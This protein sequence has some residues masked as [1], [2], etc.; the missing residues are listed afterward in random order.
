MPTDKKPPAEEPDLKVTASAPRV[1]P[2]DPV[3]EAK[4]TE[5]EPR[6]L[7]DPVDPVAIRDAQPE[8]KPKTGKDAKAET[9]AAHKEPEVMPKRDLA[10][11]IVSPEKAGAGRVPLSER[12][13][14]RDPGGGGEVNLW[15]LLQ[16]D[17]EVTVKK[18]EQGDVDEVLV[19]LQQMAARH[20]P[21][22]VAAACTARLAAIA[23]R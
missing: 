15:P 11:K 23:K 13:V 14:N 22:E 1:L 18:I 8:M 3:P 2:A 5:P 10:A 7:G 6:G 12:I 4:P 16:G 20:G 9:G 19:E 17:K 21:P